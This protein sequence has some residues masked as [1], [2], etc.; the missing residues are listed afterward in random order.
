MFCVSMA[1]VFK[2]VSRRGRSRFH[3]K[4]IQV[5]GMGSMAYAFLVV[6]LMHNVLV[7][8]ALLFFVTPML[9]TLHTLD[10]ER[11]LGMFRAGIVSLAVAVTNAAMYY[12][13]VD[14]GLLPIV[15]KVPLLM[16]VGWLLTL[17]VAERKGVTQGVDCA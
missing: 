4:T 1:V 2:S 17:H 14:V 5:A 15:Q 11:H 13:N 7:G 3:R 16:W 12:G 8:V 9:A 10:V 6:T